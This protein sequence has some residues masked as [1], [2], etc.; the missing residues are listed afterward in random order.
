ME[1]GGTHAYNKGS[2][3]PILST[4]PEVCPELIRKSPQGPAFA[5]DA[6]GTSFAAPKVTYIATQIEKSLPEAPALLYRALI[7]QSARWPQ[8]A[9]DLT[10]EDC[11]SMLRHIG[12]G[13]PDVH[14]ATSND[15]YR[16]TLIT[17]V[18]MELGDNEAHIFQIP[19]PEELS[20]VG[21]DYDILIEITL[22][23]AANPRRTRRHIKGYLSTWLDWCC[24][25]IGESAETFAQRIFETGS[26]IED[27]GDFDWVLGEATNRGFADGYSRKK[28]TLQK[29]WCIIKSNQL[30]DAFCVAVR[31]HKGW[32]GLFKA[33]YSLWQKLCC[34]Q[35][36]K[37]LERC[38]GVLL[39]RHRVAFVFPIL[40]GM[41][42][43]TECCTMCVLHIF[44]CE[45]FSL[46][47]RGNAD[48]HKTLIA[49]F[50]ECHGA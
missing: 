2:N 34:R 16:I 23:Y 42:P 12:Y 47:N 17:P 25:R 32:G 43:P 38:S 36:I 5:R 48:A 49:D 3:P 46:C 45:G 4:P 11:V 6:I 24:S 40:D 29:D 21:E 20:S 44:F 37:D 33:K 19:I 9:N 28:G 14:R 22:S 8:K 41:I 39:Q 35:I 7:A 27:D 13:I 31:G 26:V 30:S 50:L 1:Y 18:L 15:E 10:K